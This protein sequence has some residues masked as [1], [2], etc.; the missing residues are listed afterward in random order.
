MSMVVSFFSKVIIS[1]QSPLL[2]H[3]CYVDLIRLLRGGPPLVILGLCN[4]SKYEHLSSAASPPSSSCAF[5]ALTT[6]PGFF[7]K[8]R[9]HCLADDSHVCVL[10]RHYLCALWSS[11]FS[12]LWLLSFKVPW[13]KGTWL[14]DGAFQSSSLQVS[15]LAFNAFHSSSLSSCALC[16]DQAGCFFSTKRRNS[17]YSR[18]HT[19]LRSL[20]TL[21]SFKLSRRRFAPRWSHAPPPPPT[22]GLLP[23]LH[24]NL[25]TGMMSPVGS[26]TFPY[27]HHC[28]PMARTARLCLL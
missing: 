27:F 20:S 2:F 22:S 12:S 1:F 25:W 19:K 6:P 11:V 16:L 10:H 8:R 18:L 15:Q 4:G 24:T 3:L 26:D 21:T 13:R 23:V 17:R 7:P 28:R 5:S 9:Q 14:S